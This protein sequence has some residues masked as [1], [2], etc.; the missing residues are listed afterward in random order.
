MTNQNLKI[1]KRKSKKA[2]TLIEILIS[3]TIFSFAMV[4]AAGIFSGVIGNQSFAAVNSTV[5]DEGQRIIRQFSDDAVAATGVGVVQ[6]P[7]V[8]TNQY[9]SVKGFL[10]FDPNSNIIDFP[11]SCFSTG[12]NCT[13]AGVVMF[14]KNNLKIY[15]FSG[16]GIIYASD[17][18]DTLWLDSFNHI[19]QDY[20]FSQL[21]SAKTEI[22]QLEFS[23]AD[24]YNQNSCQISPIVNVLITIQTKGYD[25]KFSDRRA[26]FQ[27]KTRVALRNYQ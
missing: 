8:A 26:K 27:L 14:G 24:C 13:A 6:Q 17:S 20:I 19:S 25:L 23:G 9:S 2:F 18:S 11:A 21:N 3:L 16:K 4:I 22:S 5:N 1:G 12:G 15:R 7:G 10:F